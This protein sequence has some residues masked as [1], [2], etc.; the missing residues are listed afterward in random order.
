MHPTT[1]IEFS[2]ATVFGLA[3]SINYITPLPGV[4][5]TAKMVVWTSEP[6][7]WLAAFDNG[8][9]DPEE[10][11]IGV[12]D[13]TDYDALVARLAAEAEALALAEQ[14]EQSFV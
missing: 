13:P 6:Q 3:E 2:N 11:T 7:A 14:A 8:G 5:D 1:R 4:I 10:F 12:G 9:I